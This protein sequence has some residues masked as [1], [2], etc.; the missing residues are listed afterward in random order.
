MRISA[1]LAVALLQEAPL[2]ELKSRF[3]E[4]QD[5]GKERAVV[6][7]HGL[8]ARVVGDKANEPEPTDWQSG[9]SGLCRALADHASVFAFAYSQNRK[10]QEIAPALLPHVEKL[11][12]DGYA[13]V[14][15]V[16]FSAGGLVVRQFVEDHPKAGVR[17]VIQV[18]PPN[19]GSELGRL[20]RAVRG[21]QEAFVRS[22]RK[23]ERE[24]W[25]SSRKEVRI[26][27]GVEFVVVIGSVA[28]SG[29]GVVSRASQWSPDLRN[30]GIPALKIDALHCGAMR[31]DACVKVLC[32]LVTRP[33]PRWSA[34]DVETARKQLLD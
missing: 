9:D 25:Q 24:A 34:E 23:E 10:V 27:E 18:C 14:V 5:G 32:G 22:L 19:G 16:G 15:L 29:D 6:L 13:D 20:D 1:L 31:S 3:W 26:P 28:G 11:K 33:Q 7:V 12:T 30:Q 4:L 2:P 17:K 8:R 21:N